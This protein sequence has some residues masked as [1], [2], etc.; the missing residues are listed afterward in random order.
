MTNYFEPKVNLTY[1]IFH[2]RQTKQGIS[3]GKESVSEDAPIDAF[4]TRLRKNAKRC[5]FT[6]IDNEIKY[7][8]VFVC[9]ST[10]MRR[11]ALQ[12]DDLTLKR[13]NRQRTRVR[14]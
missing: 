10:R 1:G 9:R 3:N 11:L 4:A 6:A 14:I 13:P 7:Q 8:L 2:F 5:D 12:N